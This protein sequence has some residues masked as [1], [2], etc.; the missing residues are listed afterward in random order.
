MTNNAIY[1]KPKVVTDIEECHFYHTME[2]PGYGVQKGTFDLRQGAREYLGDVDFK[3]KR[4]LEVGTASGFLCFYMESRGAD[5]VAYDLSEED[6]GDIV[7]HYKCN[8]DQYVAERKNTIRRFNNAFW[9]SHNAFDSKAKLVHGT[10]YE[11]PR[12]IGLVDISTFGAVLLHLRDPFLA[13]QNALRLTKETVIITGG[14][15]DLLYAYFDKL[16]LPNGLVRLLDLFS[17]PQMKFVPS[18]QRPIFHTW[19]TLTPTILKRMIAI[20]G[21]EQVKVNYHWQIARNRKVRQYTI[22]GHRSRE[23]YTY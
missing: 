23:Y 2:I 13:L 17:S 1:V 3:G 5:V 20:L 12:E 19:W 10:V 7:P 22:V 4:V 11:I 15:R 9:L 14:H 8:Y 6:I 21:F 18:P 16:H